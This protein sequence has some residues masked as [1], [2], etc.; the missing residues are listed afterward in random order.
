MLKWVPN[1][2]SVEIYYATVWQSDRQG[3]T[4]NGFV[5]L[6]IRECS[7]GGGGTNGVERGYPSKAKMYYDSLCI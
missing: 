1:F 4:V 6:E 2:A 7:C 3:P 5:G